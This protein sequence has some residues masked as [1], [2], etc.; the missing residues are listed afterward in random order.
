MMSRRGEFDA[1]ASAVEEGRP[2]SGFELSD[3]AGK[4]GLGDTQRLGGAAKMQRLGD[5][6]EVDEVP[7]FEI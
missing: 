1:P 3:L 4:G 5:L 7:N 2:E 6:A